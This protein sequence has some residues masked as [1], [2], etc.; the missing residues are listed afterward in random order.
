M[1]RRVSLKAAGA[2]DA[3]CRAPVKSIFRPAAAST[4]QRITLLVS[5]LL[6]F[7]PGCMTEPGLDKAK[8]AEL[9]RTAE[10]LKA[11][12]RSGKGCEIPDAV[13]ATLT[14]GTTALRDKAAS[15]AE[16]DLLAAYADLAAICQDGLLLC[17]SRS[18][19]ADFPFVE[20]GR[21]YVTQELDPLVEKYDLPTERHLYKPTGKY[22]KSVSVDSITVIWGS[23][24]DEIRNIE[25]MLNYN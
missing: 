9:R 24:E 2:A 22:W 21:I 12:I 20:K 23:A 1:P 18:H 8:F 19:L 11:A 3:D 6:V 10:D 13:P 25:T 5:M 16:R 14:S 7:A 15:K 17:R 4:T